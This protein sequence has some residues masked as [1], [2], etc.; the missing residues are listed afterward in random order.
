M[1]VDE[2]EDNEMMEGDDEMVKAVVETFNVLDNQLSAELE[3]QTILSED[4]LKM[5]ESDKTHSLIADTDSVSNIISIISIQ[6]AIFLDPPLDPRYD[7]Q[8]YEMKLARNAI[9][10]RDSKHKMENIAMVFNKH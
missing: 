7:K 9:L 2:M 5:T 10:M 1:E 8:M 3:K 6:Q 4:W